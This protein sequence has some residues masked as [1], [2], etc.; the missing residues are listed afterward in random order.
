[1][2]MWKMKKTKLFDDSKLEFLFQKILEILDIMQALDDKVSKVSLIVDENFEEAHKRV[3]DLA[4]ENFD[5]HID[6]NNL[7][8]KIEDRIKALEEKI[9]ADS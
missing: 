9:N 8:T 1:M 3:T 7:I 2:M 5:M 6:T 4:V